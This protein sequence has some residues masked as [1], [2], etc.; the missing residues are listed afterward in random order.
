MLQM[1]KPPCG[2]RMTRLHII[3]LVCLALAGCAATAEKLAKLDAG[4][5]S[6]GQAD[7]VALKT[8]GFDSELVTLRTRVSASQ[9]FVLIKP[10]NP[11]ASVILF[12]GGHG[13]LSLTQR[14]GQLDIGWG[15][16]NFLVRSRREFAKHG[17][18]VAVVDAPSD[19]KAVGMLYGFRNSAQHV[20]D[21]EAVI[22]HLKKIT[23]LPVWLIGTSRGTESA[24][25]A[26]IHS[27]EE[28]GG[29]V[30]TSSMTVLNGKGETVSSMALDQIRVP[31]LIV[32]HKDDHCWVTPPQG[33]A[34]IAKRLVNSSQVTVRYFSLG[35]SPRSGPCQALSAHGFLGI[36]RDVL[37]AISDFIRASLK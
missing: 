17:F 6:V 7:I 18:V 35:D 32:A 8:E 20:K 16:N 37:V 2:R 24:A 10:G 19:R 5:G 29:V 26:A 1:L 22:A 34:R 13:D 15:R 14:S 31:V 3:L 36:E 4:T 28:I 33:A 11:M 30:L 25:Y 23:G 27:R 21:I 12:A 9:P